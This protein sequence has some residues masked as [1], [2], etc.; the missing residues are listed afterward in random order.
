MHLSAALHDLL[1]QTPF[2]CLAA[3]L[4][5]AILI[6][7]FFLER[8]KT[9]S[10]I[11]IGACA[12]S[13]AIA[14]NLFVQLS[15]SNTSY[16]YTNTFFEWLK[17][18][19]FSISIGSLVDPLSILMLLVVSGVGLLIH[20][21][22]VGYMEKDP[23]KGRF[24]AK[25]SFFMFAMHGIVLAP[26]LIM[27]FIFWELVGLSSY[28]LIGFW[29][30]RPH[31]AEAAK[32]AFIVNRI[33]DFG[34]LLGILIVWQIFGSFDLTKLKDPAFITYSLSTSPYSSLIGLA[35]FG[36]FCGCIGKSA[37]LPLHV[38]LPD[39]MEGP[40]P[41]SALIHA[42]TMVAAGIYLLCRVVSILALSSTVMLFIALIGVVTALFAAMIATQQ[43]D[44]KRILAYSTLSQLGYMVM[45]VGL[46]YWQCGMFHLVTHAFFK[47]LLFLGAG[48]VIHSLHHQQNIW[49]MGGLARKMPITAITFIIGTLALIGVPFF[50]GFYSKE[51][52]LLAALLQNKFCFTV[53]LATAALTAYYMTRLVVLAFFSTSKSEESKHAHESGFI[54]TLPLI[55]LAI[56]SIAAGF[57][58]LDSYL[59]V[60]Q[61]LASIMETPTNGHS[62]IHTIVATLS[63]ASLIAGALTA[64]K[65]YQGARKEPVVLPLLANKFYIDEFYE[66][67]LLRFQERLANFLSWLDRWILEG[68]TMR[69]PSAAATVGGEILRL[70]Q[71]GNVRFYLAV[72]IVGLIWILD[73]L[74]SASAG[75]SF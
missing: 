29:Y 39:A 10:F 28:L 42:A 6:T 44:I 66:R 41:V 11:S 51:S 31:A 63:I 74:F 24:F 9:A 21:F 49:Q 16:A 30:K 71:S 8:K 37:Q 48:S 18:G 72:L 17:L 47:A 40:T 32:K 60:S 56:L 35:A 20:I 50:S 4:L 26:N 65:I 12:I 70:L 64:F 22:S 33:G 36:L 59:G 15:S 25:L 67:T 7:L 75:L 57:I 73:R 45:A 61:L 55:L 52:I 3:P 19:A 38:W 23:G 68:I 53:A 69:T 14:I 27:L 62:N 34:F 58:G 46:G 13:F 43:N 2:L 1:L 54:M 5:S